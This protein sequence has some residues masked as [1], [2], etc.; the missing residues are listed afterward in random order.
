MPRTLG[1]RQLLQST[2]AVG[3][4]SVAGCLSAAGDSPEPEADSSE[5]PDDD[6]QAAELSPPES[7]DE[8]L[9]SAN[10]YTGD[11][12]RDGISSRVEIRVGHEYDDGLGFA[13]VVVEVPPRTTVHWNWTGHGGIHN[14]VALDGTFD[15]GRPNA[16]HGTS[17]QFFFEETGT[18]PFVSE[19]DRDDGMKGVVVVTEPPSTGY[20]EVDEWVVSSSNFDGEITDR[21]DAETASVTVGVEGNGDHFAF[22]PPVVKIS[23]DT[24]VTWEW[25]DHTGP[26]NISFKDADIDS[27]E[28]TTDAGTTF[29]HTFEETG[30]YRYSSVPH[31][32]L[33][34]RGAII[35]E[36]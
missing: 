3:L 6:T 1:R 18:Y 31:T 22:G 30:I 2:A 10:G 26:T 25:S 16:Q 13:P 7:V 36:E 5:S 28:P 14:V 35:V 24:T 27:G 33:G 32:S 4:L 20:E 11:R 17:Y 8:W 29:E 9:E 19:P 12:T 34:M 23:P 15:S 21:T